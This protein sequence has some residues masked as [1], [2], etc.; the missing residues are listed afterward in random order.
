MAATTSLRQ[1]FYL[2]AQRNYPGWWISPEGKVEQ[3]DTTHAAF[4]E[5]YMRPSAKR[6]QGEAAVNH[7][8]DQ[9]WI[10]AFKTLGMLAYN[11]KA[12][13]V[14]ELRKRLQRILDHAKG[15][16]ALGIMLLVGDQ[17]VRQIHES[18]GS[19]KPQVEL[20]E[21]TLETVQQLNELLSKS[22]KDLV[23]AMDAYEARESGVQQPSTQPAVGT[24]PQVFTSLNRNNR[25]T[26][27]GC[28]GQNRR[29]FEETREMLRR[30]Q[31]RILASQRR[32]AAARTL[33][34]IERM[35]VD[36]GST[37]RAGTPGRRP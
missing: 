10:R 1:V 22:D 28:C 27:M 24:R 20:W 29:R 14:A 12:R 15:H 23:E 32:T 25:R 30:R 3:V 9:G 31:R 4:A 19:Y 21:F 8:L 6:L 2:I 34:D 13:S 16:N 11:F 35:L 17:S 5:R 36:G 26:I 33:R 18:M 7:W 37:F